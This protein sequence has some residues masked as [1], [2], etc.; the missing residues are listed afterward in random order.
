MTKAVLTNPGLNLIDMNVDG[1]LYRFPPGLSVTVEE[2]LAP[3][4]IQMATISGGSLTMT[5]TVV[6]DEPVPAPEPVATPAPQPK[7]L[8]KRLKK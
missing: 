2:A 7:K 8:T 1:T 6:P 5:H 3:R 4:L